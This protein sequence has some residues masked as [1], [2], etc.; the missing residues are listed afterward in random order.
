MNPF[1]KMWIILK[2]CMTT[3]PFKTTVIYFDDK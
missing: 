3:S 2:I 1:Y